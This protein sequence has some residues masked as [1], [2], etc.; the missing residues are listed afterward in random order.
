MQNALITTSFTSFRLSTFPHDVQKYVGIP[1]DDEDPEQYDSCL[2]Y[3]LD[4]AN[5]TNED[6]WNWNR[7]S[8]ENVTTSS[9]DAWVYDQSEFISTINSQVNIRI[10]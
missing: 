1:Y 4:Y 3:D 5:M 8:T 2:F 7:N 10:W 6:I 9:C